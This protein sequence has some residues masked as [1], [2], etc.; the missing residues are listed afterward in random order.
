MADIR[1]TEVTALK[2]IYGPE[3]VSMP[4]EMDKYEVGSSLTL[5]A[6]VGGSRTY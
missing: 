4:N 2:A 3:A 1:E 6:S 5:I